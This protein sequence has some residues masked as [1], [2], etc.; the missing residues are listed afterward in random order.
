MNL[1]WNNVFLVFYEID[2]CRLKKWD[3]GSIFASFSYH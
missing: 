2:G 1:K 3:A